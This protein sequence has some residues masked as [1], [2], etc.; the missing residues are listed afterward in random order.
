VVWA[1]GDG[2]DGSEA[3]REVARR[4]AAERPRLVL[5]L[6]D[7]YADGSA[8]EFRE[9]FAAVY[10][11]LVERMAPT[12]GNH[13]WP[14]HEEGYDPYWESVT[15][16]PTPP[17]YAFSAGGW[18]FISLNSEAAEDP[19]QL[20]WLRRELGSGD[21]TCRLAFWHRPRFSAGEH[22]D[23]KGVAPLWNAVRGRASL[24][25]NAHDHDLQRLRPRDGIVELV[26]GAGGH[27]RREVQEEDPRLAFSSDEDSGAL[28]MRLRPGAAELE[29]VA[30]GG[31]VLDRTTVTCR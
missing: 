1:V 21:G 19:R 6:G 27:S 5:Y 24:V 15:G 17:W 20:A 23:Q 22:G 31:A 9:N 4:I 7:V 28:R 10:G 2:G 30:A 3:A 14:S 16:A 29:F 8:E 25:L 18:R 26:V 12:P 11:P 13:E